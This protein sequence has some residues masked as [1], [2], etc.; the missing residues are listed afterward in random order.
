MDSNGSNTNGS[1]EVLL[2]LLSQN[3]SLGASIPKCAGCGLLI[4][5]KFILKILDKNWHSKC[6]R[7]NQCGIQLKEKC[8]LKNNDVFC[9]DD[10]FRKYGPK[11]GQCGTGIPPSDVIRRAQDFVY[12]LECFICTICCK[13]L[14]TGD[15]YYLMEDK[16]LLCKYDY[17]S[18]RNS[19]D[20]NKRP[21]TT[22]TARQME[23]LK[24]AYK[25]SPKPARHIR[26]QLAQ[27]TGLDMR[28]VQVWFQNRRAKEK[29]RLKKDAGR[30]RWGQYFQGLKPSSSPPLDKRDS[31]R[32]SELDLDYNQDS[33]NDSDIYPDNGDFPP[34]PE[35]WYIKY[36][37]GSS[38]LSQKEEGV[39]MDSQGR[40]LV[41]CDNGTG[42]VKCGFAGKNLPTHVF[43]SLWMTSWWGE[44][45][46]KLRS[47]LEVSYPMENGMV[48]NWEDMKH[49]WDYTFGP[50]KLNITPSESKILLTEPP[51]NPK[52]N[53]EKMVEVM[54]EEYGFNGLFVAIQAILTLYSQ[55]LLTGI[56]VD[57][58]DGVTHICPVCRGFDLPHLTRRL[59]IAG[60]DVTRYLIKL[61]LLRG[62][63][64]NH[65]ADFETVRILKEKLCYMGYDIAKEEKLARE[66][67]FLVERYTL[68]DGRVIN[69]GGERFE[70][71][72]ALFQPHLINVEGP[73]M[74][75]LLFNCIQAAD[76]DMRSD[77][78]KHIV[79]SGGSTMYPGLPSRLERELRQLYL[80]RVLK[81]DTSRLAKYKMRVEVPPTR[82]NSVFIGG[83]ILANIMKDRD[84]FWIEKSEYEEKGESVINK[85]AYKIELR[86]NH[87]ILGLFGLLLRASVSVWPHSGKGSPP[88]YG[89]YEAQR[90]WQEV[91]L[92]LPISSWYAPG[93]KGN[94]LNYWGLD[95]P[96]LT[97]YHSYL[98]GLFARD[99]LNQSHYVELEKSRG[100]ESPDH[101][102][103]MRS[104]VLFA[105][106]II[107]LPALYYAFKG[108]LLGF[109]MLITYPGLILIDNGHFQ[110]NNI[111]LGLFIMAVNCIMRS[112]D[113]LGSFLFVC[114]L[115]YKQMELYHA[116]PFFFYLL[117]SSLKKE[118]FPM[119]SL[120]KLIQIGVIVLGSFALIWF[121]FIDPQQEFKSLKQVI[122]RIFPLARGVFEDKVANFWCSLNLFI[123]VKTI[124]SQEE[125]M[126]ICA[127]VTGFVVLPSNVHLFL[128]P[129]LRNFLCSLSVTSLGF[130][131]FSFQVHEKSILLAV[132][133][134][135]I[136]IYSTRRD[137]SNAHLIATWLSV[138]S[139]FSMLP[140]L[141][142]DGMTMAQPPPS[143]GGHSYSSLR[144]RLDEMGYFQSFLPECL[145]L[146]EA[147]FNDLLTTTHTLKLHKDKLN[148]IN[149]SPSNSEESVQYEK[150]E[151]DLKNK[152]RDLEALNS[153]AL[154]V[155]STL[156]EE[157]LEKSR[158]LLKLESNKARVVEKNLPS[159]KPK[160]EIT[161]YVK[162]N[163]R[164]LP[165]SSS[166]STSSSSNEKKFIHI[167]KEGTL[168]IV[169]MFERKNK[170]LNDLIFKAEEEL[171]SQKQRISELE[172]QL[173]RSSR[174][175][176]EN[177]HPKSSS[178][179]SKILKDNAA[180]REKIKSLEVNPVKSSSCIK[181]A[182]HHLHHQH[183][184]EENK[185]NFKSRSQVHKH[186]EDQ[187]VHIH[188]LEDQLRSSL[189]EIRELKLRIA[190]LQTSK[191]SF[192]D[193]VEILQAQQK[194]L[195]DSKDASKVNE[196]VNFMEKQRNIYRDNVHE[197]L[198]QL[199]I[200]GTANKIIPPSKTFVKEVDVIDGICKECRGKKLLS[201]KEKNDLISRLEEQT[202]QIKEKECLITSGKDKIEEWKQRAMSATS[203]EGITQECQYLQTELRSSR[204][205]VVH[206][207]QE[208]RIKDDHLKTLSDEKDEIICLLDDKTICLEKLKEEKM[209]MIN[210]LNQLDSEKV[211]TDHRVAHAMSQLNAIQLELKTHQREKDEFRGKFEREKT[212]EKEEAQSRESDIKSHIQKY[213]NEVKR[214][215]ELLSLCEK[216]RS[217]LLEQYRRLSSDVS[218]AES[219]GRRLETQVVSLE[220]DLKSRETELNA[221]ETRLRNLEKDLAEMSLSN[222][223]YR[224]QLASFT[225]RADLAE[226]ELKESRN[227]QSWINKDLSNVHDLAVELL[228]KISEQESEINS[229]S[230]EID[231]LRSEL[232]FLRK[233]Y[234]E[235][236]AK[237]K[238]L[239]GKLSEYSRPG[240][241]S[242]TYS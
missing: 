7:C 63:S 109:G 174:S 142:R 34:S 165:P 74:A 177:Y 161:C 162:E 21:R 62:Y 11:C 113:L 130:F 211:S 18:A 224:L 53:R 50:E 140:L 191:K 42:F 215:E 102:L 203:L 137:S 197:L 5:D 192:K 6:L 110:Y 65:T 118:S 217:E 44:K 33:A 112:H 31:D 127:I 152:I 160:M 3:K 126:K 111:S 163:K 231:K 56:V 54:F 26:E 228:N 187:H 15:E 119:G 145:P 199:N 87:L 176:H 35:S 125:L 238:N 222:E 229:M 85:L 200:E 95:Y 182:C 116:L 190:H 210:D 138:I 120:K 48:R 202:S 90:H 22:I 25:N 169:K 97:A 49:L 240:S 40:R 99:V 172:D 88:M 235:E 216:E 141:K 98:N 61:L 10:F 76:I 218:T 92:N 214:I 236:R 8:F 78:Y 1:T 173:K 59:D 179:I 134:S 196:L 184:D 154:N 242:S 205:K 106:L 170:I 144:E 121:P 81:G 207:S 103:Y 225:V 223:N 237:T 37:S 82:Q 135:L 43:P 32:D 175:V 64:F 41:V 164:K 124:Y 29:K 139:I 131:L 234:H 188:E 186:M 28:V 220:M 212:V 66:T 19:V 73:G 9:K 69:V 45:V 194:V 47:M 155:V 181:S 143:G 166:S 23:V 204:D 91:T 158:K 206:L 147:L 58:G 39:I 136:W 171:L 180:L 30:A 133:P 57:S 221:A 107:L 46:S 128:R 156:Q 17:E 241:S 149:S 72:E 52:R 108:N 83:A 77:L 84:N 96:P 79:L 195:V 2:A 114:A 219:Y 14:D 208:L 213:I 16:K 93:V 189:D 226:S 36:W 12:H 185:E 148:A 89:D 183:R 55:G 153:H 13:K 167:P 117:G 115:C 178:Y 132:I 198:E 94:E 100:M 68:P 232:I 227:Q 129:N 75:E 123:K 233:E 193:K 60:R 159:M 86:M 201:K 67:T 4:L 209:Q 71:P 27:D 104:T 101:I 80:E 105:D 150:K 151:E 20:G 239:E 122:F 51:M 146:V 38:S 24:E 168:D 70:A 157:S 230:N